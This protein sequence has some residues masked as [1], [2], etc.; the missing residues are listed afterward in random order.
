MRV[1]RSVAAGFVLALAATVHAQSSYTWT[2]VTQ[3][4]TIV[5]FPQV[6]RI[7]VHPHDA[8]RLLA[9]GI[10]GYL[11][12]RGALHSHT[13]AVSNDAGATWGPPASFPV[14][15]FYSSERLY[16]HVGLPGVVFLSRT[17]SGS[18]SGG[19][20]GGV[21]FF[22]SD[23]FGLHWT[24]GY[25]ARPGELGV[26]PIG[27]DPFD[28]SHLFATV[29]SAYVCIRI[30]CTTPVDMSIVESRDGGASWSAPLPGLPQVPYPW[31]DALYEH[32]EGPTPAAPRRMFFAKKDGVFVT[33]DGGHTW[34]P[35]NGGS[36]GAL[37][38]VRQDPRRD[39]VLYALQR[40]PETSGR[41]KLL[42]SDDAGGTWRI[43]FNVE[44]QFQVSDRGPMVTIDP[45]RSH[46]VWLTGLD[47]GV[48]RSSDAGETWQYMGFAAGRIWVGT[49]NE[50]LDGDSI[51]KDLAISASDPR[52]V[53][54]IHDR[55]LYR[56]EP[57]ARPELVVSEFQYEGDRYW[58]T[59]LDGEALSQDYRLEP[60]DVRRTGLRFGAWRADNAPVGALGSCRFWSGP[61]TGLRTRV[62]L[63]NDGECAALKRVPGWILEAENEF[64]TV[65]PI[66][67]ACPTGLIP[68]RRFNNAKYD[69]NHRWVTDPV[70]AAQMRA[71]HWYDEG[72]RFCARP[73]GSN[74]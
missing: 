42:R 37:R 9:T 25:T 14:P 12:E 58:L 11:D 44:N 38:W 24:P 41:T 52:V 69:L 1:F 8:R 31:F 73:L 47:V 49:E 51:V 54:L 28:T 45:V 15:S 36:A 21:A 70:V 27:S 62:L 4:N 65:A 71:R 18:A 16:S 3:A 66:A 40:E 63:L 17:L 68:V 61:G 64:Y 55:R 50:R 33:Q 32:V 67:G 7:A 34:A 46:E 30:G 60:G 5:S 53:Y 10:F 48:F 20:G 13:I 35:F 29:R 39:N 72:V 59:S 56:G 22:R 19:P 43:I 23:D 6:V 26:S 57:S 74:E 2:D